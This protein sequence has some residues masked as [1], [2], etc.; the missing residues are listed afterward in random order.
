MAPAAAPSK[1]AR[2]REDE[3]PETSSTDGITSSLPASSS[4]LFLLQA[5][6]AQT[7][8]G[9]S[10]AIHS[11]KE[12]PHA[13]L[14]TRKETSIEESGRL[15]A[16]AVFDL[17]DEIHEDHEEDAPLMNLMGGGSA[18]HLPSQRKASPN[19]DRLRKKDNEVD[20]NNSVI[21]LLSDENDGEDTCTEDDE[22]KNDDDEEGENEPILADFVEEVDP[23]VAEDFRQQQEQLHASAS[24]S[25]ATK[26]VADSSQTCFICGISLTDRKRRLDHIKRC[27]KRHGVTARDVRLNDDVELFTNNDDQVVR[28]APATASVNPYL[29]RKN[30]WHGDSVADLAVGSTNHHTGGINNSNK[31]GAPSLNQMLM[32]GARRAA[33]T[34]LLQQQQK[35][36]AINNKKR[37]YNNGFGQKKPYG[38]C[39]SFKKIPGTDYCVDGFHYADPALTHNYFLTHFHSDHYGGITKHWNAGVIFCSLPTANLVHEQLG[40]DR[41]FLHP[42]PLLTPTVLESKG[43]PVTV[44][45]LDANHC[46]GAIMFLFE[47]GKRVILHVGDFRWNYGIMSRQAP[48]RPYCRIPWSGNDSEKRIDDVYFDTTYCDPQYSLPSQAECIEAASEVAVQEVKSARAAKSRLLMLFGA[49]TIGKEAVYMSV[50]TKL[51]LKVY[52]DKRRFR[53]LSALEW[54]TEKLSILTTNPQDTILWV[55][56]LGH[57]NMRKMPS[58]QKIRMRGFSRDFDRVVGFRP[59]GWSLSSKKKDSGS[60]VGTTTRGS[61]TVHSVPYSEHSSFPELV[62]C[63]ESLNPRRIIPTVSVSKSQQQIDLLLSAWRDKQAKLL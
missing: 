40:V 33:K 14:H 9:Q 47:V 11:N 52:V 20:A 17:Y 25:V 8:N 56:P 7:T 32:A 31:A 5:R 55:V 50:A 2:G 63:L 42:L 1:L 24:I 51:G 3:Q 54:P 22:E 43:K 21:D 34:K 28:P 37:R 39:P 35:A 4:A 30:D 44:T 18:S 15:S 61:L 19:N 58:Y 60:V 46:P 29:R 27:S 13:S 12:N 10:L 38:A 57:I 49:Y 48:L 26:T 16:A 41:Q 59:T 45:L 36:A 53:I 62:E 23:I 6:S